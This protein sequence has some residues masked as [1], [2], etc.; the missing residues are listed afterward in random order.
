MDQFGIPEKRFVTHDGI[1]LSYWI[2][3]PDPSRD[4]G[5]TL[6]LANGIGISRL[7]WQDIVTAFRDRC[8]LLFWD[9]RSFYRSATPPDPSQLKLECH[10]RDA[11]GLLAHEKLEQVVMIG[12]SMGVQ[13]S[14]E[15]WRFAGHRQVGFVLMNGTSGRTFDT[16]FGVPGLIYWIPPLTEYLSRK[17]PH[18]LNRVLPNVFRR[19]LSGVMQTA[20]VVARNVDRVLLERI[21]EEYAQLDFGVYFYIL[22]SL[23]RHAP[24]HLGR[25]KVPALVLVG[26]EDTFTPPLAGKVLRSALPLAELE[27]IEH[28]THYMI[29]EF[30]QEIRKLIE[31]FLEN[32]V[33]PFLQ[34]G[35]V[36]WSPAE[37]EGSTL[38][39]EQQDLEKNDES[40]DAEG[41]GRLR[42]ARARLRSRLQSLQQSGLSSSLR[43]ALREGWQGPQSPPKKTDL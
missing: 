39:V 26:S 10:A 31:G 22:N 9:Y 38:E 36:Q 33:R 20:G 30:Q 12:W 32:R 25:I 4:S 8:T 35:S 11:A 2:S 18:H 16:A 28:G 27:R 29:L 7:V 41:Q 40:S 42:R 23:G 3:R 13:V 1:P 21:L 17:H 14:L 43:E 19:E 37:A 34:S 5:L 24:A 15:S 6:C